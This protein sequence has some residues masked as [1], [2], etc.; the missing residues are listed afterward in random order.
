MRIK[1]LQGGNRIIAF[2]L[3]LLGFTYSCKDSYMADM[4][5]SPYA[6]YIVNGKVVSERDN[7]SIKGIQ[8]RISSS[9]GKNTSNTEALSSDTNGNYSVM[10][11]EYGIDQIN[12]SFEDVDGPE[13]GSFQSVDT[14]MT[15]SKSDLSGKVGSWFMGSS[16]KILNIKLKQKQ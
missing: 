14:L 2:F 6:E 9:H 7:S 15:F 8:I 13:N 16:E 11:T 3:T 1:L 5:G 4:Y 12:L 10:Y